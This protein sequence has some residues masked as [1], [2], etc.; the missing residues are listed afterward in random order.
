MLFLQFPY[1]L[2]SSHLPLPLSDLQDLTRILPNLFQDL[3]LSIRADRMY[4]LT[5]P[6]GADT[7][8]RLHTG[9]LFLQ[10]VCLPMHVGKSG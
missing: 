10:E 6:H 5:L 1:L 8:L 3:H 2:R 7:F 4:T 9:Y